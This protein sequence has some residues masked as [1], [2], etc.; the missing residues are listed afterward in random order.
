MTLS[1]ALS[2][3]RVC[4]FA[5]IAASFTAQKLKFPLPE[6]ILNVKL[7]FLCKVSCEYG[8]ATSDVIHDLRLAK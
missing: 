6:E 1:S 4:F 3:N 7:H 2:R 5:Q 8:L